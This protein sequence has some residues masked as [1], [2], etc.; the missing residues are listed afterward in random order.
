MPHWRGHLAERA[1]SGGIDDAAP[2]YAFFHAKRS[3]D[4]LVAMLRI[5]IRV[6]TICY[7]AIHAATQ[8][9]SKFR[10]VEHSHDHFRPCLQ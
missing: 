1:G 7:T 6:Q 4:Y 5:A 3:C 8:R 10:L 2:L 9:P